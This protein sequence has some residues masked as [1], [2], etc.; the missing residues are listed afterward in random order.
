[1]LE[2]FLV[3]VNLL[4]VWVIMVFIELMSLWVS[5]VDFGELFKLVGM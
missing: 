1:M 5:C 3:M 2:G 4:G